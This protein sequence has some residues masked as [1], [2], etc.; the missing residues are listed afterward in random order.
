MLM[1]LKK[2]YTVFLWGRFVFSQLGSKCIKT[3]ES[4]DRFCT[5]SSRLQTVAAEIR[6][7][8]SNK[9]KQKLICLLVISF[10][11]PMKNQFPNHVWWDNYMSKMFMGSGSCRRLC[12]SVT[13]GKLSAARLY[14]CGH[15]FNDTENLCATQKYWFFGLIVLRRYKRRTYGLHSF[16]SER[17]GKSLLSPNKHKELELP[18][19]W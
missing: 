1:I 10:P 14:L 18:E 6:D 9:Q 3:T 12:C 19:S 4:Y 2:T 15:N 16:W 13:A 8:C 17:L 5:P 7:D 11:R